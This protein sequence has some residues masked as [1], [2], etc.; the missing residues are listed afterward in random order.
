MKTCQ[1]TNNNVIKRRS[2]CSFQNSRIHLIHPNFGGGS[3]IIIIDTN[4]QRI[5]KNQGPIIQL[6]PPIIWPYLSLNET[7]D[8][9]ERLSPSNCLVSLC[10]EK[11][12]VI[13]MNFWPSKKDLIFFLGCW[14]QG[15]TICSALLNCIKTGHRFRLI[16]CILDQDTVLFK[17]VQ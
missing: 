3:C 7:F 14:T 6:P 5:V 15:A 11:V 4:T 17:I 12:I 8:I 13:W 9:T 10:W 2:L 16:F 1:G